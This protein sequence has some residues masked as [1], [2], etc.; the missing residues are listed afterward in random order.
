MSAIDWF[1]VLTGIRENLKPFY[2]ATGRPSIDHELMIRMLIVATAWAC[3]RSGGC[4]KR[5][6]SL[7]PIA[8]SAAA[9]WMARCPITRLSPVKRHRCF[10]DSGPLR[11]LLETKGERSMAEGLV[12]THGLVVEASV[13]RADVQHQ[14]SVLGQDGLPRVD[15]TEAKTELPIRR[16]SLP[17]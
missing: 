6:I 14:R 3:G 1:V 9:I 2:S 11:K 17:S 7:S 15:H 16:G 5:R 8:S 12:G 4:A 13:I 10:H